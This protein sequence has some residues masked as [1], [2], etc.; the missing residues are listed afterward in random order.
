MS[1]IKVE[2]LIQ[3]KKRFLNEYPNTAIGF[4]PDKKT[5]Q[6]GIE[7]RVAFEKEIQGIPKEFEGMKVNALPVGKSRLE[8]L[9]ELQDNEVK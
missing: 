4:V 1:K 6:I 3:I 8:T 7:A 2:D 9:K 5:K